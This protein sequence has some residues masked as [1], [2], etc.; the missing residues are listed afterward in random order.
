MGSLHPAIVHIPIGLLF[1]YSLVEIALLFIPKYRTKLEAGKY[2]MLM[3]GT[4]G[5]FL[6]LQTG[7]ALEDLYAGVALVDMHALFAASTMW[8]YAIL[9]GAFTI[10]YLEKWPPIARVFE[11]S[12]FFTL[13][14]HRLF[15]IIH[16][17]VRQPLLVLF[18]I[19]G[20]GLLTITGALGGA[21]T[22]GPDADPF[23]RF[24]YSLF[25]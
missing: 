3:V 4:F 18:A 10:V 21:I 6:A 16:Y 17:I 5:G 7:D 20:L 15:L 11:R 9:A 22:H 8:V 1:L 24:I 14:W 12:S 19:A 13:V 23:V 2:L 25:F